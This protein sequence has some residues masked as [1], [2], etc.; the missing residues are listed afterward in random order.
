[1]YTEMMQKHAVSTC[2]LAAVFYSHVCGGYFL[3]GIP[4]YLS[5]A[6]KLFNALACLAF[7]SCSL[8][9]FLPCCMLGMPQS[10]A[11]SNLRSTAAG[12]QHLC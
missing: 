3:P 11:L 4:W 8:E 6:V 9:I 1:M 12:G 10:K 7:S 2:L 5:N